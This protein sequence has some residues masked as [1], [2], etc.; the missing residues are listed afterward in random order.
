MLGVY[1]AWHYKSKSSLRLPLTT[2]SS[3]EKSF[4]K[5]CVLVFGSENIIIETMVKG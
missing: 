1:S 4:D 5:P 2:R 3:T